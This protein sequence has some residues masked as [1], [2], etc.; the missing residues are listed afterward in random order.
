MQCE[1]QEKFAMNL[2][3]LISKG[4]KKI[5]TCSTVEDTTHWDQVAQVSKPKDPSLYHQDKQTCKPSAHTH[6][7]LSHSLKQ[8]IKEGN[9]R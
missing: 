4:G 2:R 6:P 3:Y 7:H 9:N 8:F 1:D 5:L